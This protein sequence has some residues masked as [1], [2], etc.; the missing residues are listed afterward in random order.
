MSPSTVAEHSLTDTLSSTTC[1]P[2]SIVTSDSLS[3]LAMKDVSNSVRSHR[4]TV[5]PKKRPSPHGVQKSRKQ[6]PLH[7]VQSVPR[8]SPR[9]VKAELFAH[10]HREAHILALRREGILLE[11]EYREEIKFYMHEMEV[12]GARSSPVTS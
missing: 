12:S 9:A 1:S 11:E 3:V 2:P 10:R 7:P 8:K 6:S 4:S 5:Y